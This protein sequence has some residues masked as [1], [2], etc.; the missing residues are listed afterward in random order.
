MHHVRW[1]SQ[2]LP[3]STRAAFITLRGNPPLL[4]IPRGAFAYVHYVTFAT[5]S[6]MRLRI[7]LGQYRKSFVD[8]VR[9]SSLIEHAHYQVDHFVLR[10][11]GHFG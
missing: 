7:P 11:C 3:Y 9:M 8:L 10:Q 1:I 6:I 5:C 4:R 2:V